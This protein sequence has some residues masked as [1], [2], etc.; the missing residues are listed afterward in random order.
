MTNPILPHEAQALMNSYGAKHESFLFAFDFELRQAL[1]IDHPLEQQEILF[2]TPLGSNSP[3]LPKNIDTTLTPHPISLEDYRQRFEVVSRGLHR[4]NSFLTNLT[5]RTPIT[6]NVPLSDIFHTSRAP[7]CLLV[8]KEFVCFSPEIFVR[9]EGNTISTY[10]MKGTIDAT[11]PHASETI[12]AD[13]KEM[14]EHVTVVDLLRN[15]IGLNANNVEV[16]RFRYIDKIDTPQRSILQVSSKIK[17]NLNTNW[18]SHLGDILFKMLPAGSVSGAPKQA[19]LNI[20]RKAEGENRGFYTG[21]FGYFDGEKLDSGVLIRY[22]EE[23]EG[24]YFFRSGGGI[25]V[26]SQCETEYKE[27][28]EK[29][30]LPTK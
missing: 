12:L 3:I 20:I 24:K 26:N 17:G 21:V 13:K 11:L 25:T 15:D 1:F 19:T 27:V 4:G 23:V 16:S 5:L 30:Y 2:R 22:I 7:Y 18:H 8:P 14:A 9:I 28:I 6:L 10:P 29:I